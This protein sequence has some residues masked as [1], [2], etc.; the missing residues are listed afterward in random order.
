MHLAVLLLAVSIS[1]ASAVG[2][3]RGAGRLEVKQLDSKAD[4]T[5]D[6]LSELA[7]HAKAV[8]STFE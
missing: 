4:G 7:S 1:G 8:L 2:G 3:V 6:P 5:A